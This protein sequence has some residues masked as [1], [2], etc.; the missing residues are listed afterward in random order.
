VKIHL[1]FV[2]LLLLGGNLLLADPPAPLVL[3]P[4][5]PGRA[6]EGIGCVSAGASSRLLIEYPEPQ[7]SQILDY[8]FKPNYGA[9]FQHLKVEVGSDMNSTDGT[10]PSH[11]RT[12]DDLNF[13]RGYEWWLMEEAKKRNPDI[14][15]DCLAW[16]APAWIGDG[17]YY[18]QDMADYLVKFLQGA[19]SAHG[20][21]IDY[22]GIWNE[23]GY[24]TEWIKLL[25][26]TLD[27]AGLQSVGIAAADQI[28][29]WNIVDSMAKDPQLA[30]AIHAVAVHYPGFNSSP[31]AQAC[32]LPLWSSEDGPW[33][34][35][36]GAARSLARDFN[37]NYIVG[38]MTKTEI[39]SPV[40]SYYD[41][42][43][44][45]SSGVMRANTPWSGSYEVQP[46]VW[47][48]AH[49]TQFARPGWIYM[50]SA[51]RMLEGGSIVA[52]RSPDS[53]DY[54]LIIETTEAKAPQSL[55]VELKGSL[56]PGPLHVWK[57]T[58]KESFQDAGL[59]TPEDH[60]FS[61]TVDPE[62]I[63]SF[64]TVATPRK[65]DAVP[66]PARAFPLPYAEDF[67]KYPPAATP[68]YFSD[69]GGAFEVVKDL[70]GNAL[71]QVISQEGIAW[72]KNPFP[73]TFLGDAQWKD[74]AVSVNALVEKG[75]FASLFGRVGR[76]EQNGNP[77][78]GFWLKADTSG[79]WELAVRREK[80]PPPGPKPKKEGEQV[81]LASGT[82]A[83]AFAPDQWHALKLVF[84][85]THITAFIDGAKVADVTSDLAP[86]GMAGIGSGWHGSRF[87]H[88]RIDPLP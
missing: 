88:F 50:D 65:G 54:S 58:G 53:K 47:G 49:T 16:A 11:M 38:K 40:S 13:G 84:Q 79:T 77:P 52:L 6:F 15:L 74:Y 42:L 3:D 1:T 18:S 39:W 60:R 62:A 87:Q 9:G 22:V 7:R 69:Y 29:N 73:E 41:N 56:P 83:A 78:W 8:L 32:G 59:V 67:D 25:R 30:T 86:A 24:Q 10:E 27:R 80:A 37:R 34:G 19:K 48:T 23:R 70:Q 66:P 72:Q 76:I 71:R 14:I 43:P 57:T 64:T 81:L 45:S 46:A 55:S 75:G 5:S 2:T 17:K 31:A 21:R 68:R 85:G 26:Q 28:R 20:L 12:R 82:T 44:L 33:S 63:Y 51:C 35:G 4:T 61:L 36:W